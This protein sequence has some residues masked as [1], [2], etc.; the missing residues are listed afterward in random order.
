MVA[1]MSSRSGR[2]ARMSPDQRRAAIIDATLPLVFQHGNR[3]TVRL[4]A[5]A[6][7]I[8]EGT[9]F[10]VFPD[11]DALMSAVIAKGF[12]PEPT[13][14]ALVEID[15]ALPLR[16]RLV[17]A[18]EITQ[19]GLRRSFTLIAALGLSAPPPTSGDRAAT[20]RQGHDRFLAALTR[21]I[22]PDEHLLSTSVAELADLVRLLT[23]SATHP[24]INDGRPLSAERIV[25]VL[26]D[27]T[28]ARSRTALT[29]TSGGN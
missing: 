16:E 3:V 13:R 11:K 23:F 25:E 5:E 8:A 21:V 1:R 27:G 17:A 12:D 18:V 29:T 20:L 28:R 7:G 26:L 10:T 14:R 9:I 2:A 6:A 19:A 22:E 15:A 4:I 24:L